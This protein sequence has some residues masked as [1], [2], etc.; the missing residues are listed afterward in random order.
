MRK[1]ANASTKSTLLIVRRYFLK[2]TGSVCC[3]VR[4]DA[5]D[6]QVWVHA[7]GTTACDCEG[8]AVYGRT[9]KHIKFVLAK[10][11]ARPTREA[12]RAAKLA[13]VRAAAAPAVTAIDVQ[14]VATIAAEQALPPVPAAQRSEQARIADLPEPVVGTLNGANH[15]ANFFLNL[16]SRQRKVS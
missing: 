5:H 7:N 16:P 4:S 12:E 10:E 11:A 15:S 13:A 3:I 2:Q 6:Y 14:T 1:S 9:C 8:R